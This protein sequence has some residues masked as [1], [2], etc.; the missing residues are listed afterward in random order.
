MIT[1]SAPIVGFVKAKIVE[2]DIT[3]APV[4]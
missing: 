2:N 3:L 1:G 4:I